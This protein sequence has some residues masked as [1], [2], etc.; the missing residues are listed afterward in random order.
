MLNKCGRK[1]LI[2]DHNNLVLLILL[3]KF[4]TPYQ[5]KLHNTNDFKCFFFYFIVE[6]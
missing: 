1:V 6:I 3:F 2:L 5:I 4:V